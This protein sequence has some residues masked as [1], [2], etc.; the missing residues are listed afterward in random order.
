MNLALRVV[1]GVVLVAVIAAALWIGTAAVAVV[2]GLGALIGAWEL[3][4][5]LGRM[6]PT[7]PVWLT[8]PLSVFLSIRFVLPASDMAADWAFAAAVVVGLL[9]GLGLRQSFAGWA[10]AV[11]GATYVGLCLGFWVAIYRWHIQD[12]NHLGFR[13]V[14]LALAGAVIGDSAAYFVGSTIGRHPF[15]HSISPRKSLEGAIAGAVASLLVGALAGPW[16]IG[17]SVPA[18]AGLGALMAVATWSSQR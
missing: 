17:I 8:L 2:V 4:G 13:L 15:F 9:A 5:L 1:S 12:A 11:G 16:L 18:G 6:G 10:L 7:P 14:V 3:R